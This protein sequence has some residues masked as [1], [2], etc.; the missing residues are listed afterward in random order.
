MGTGLYLVCLIDFSLLVFDKGI[1]SAS[2]TVN[3]FGTFHTLMQRIEEK[4]T[5]TSDRPDFR[6]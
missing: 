6:I 2:G 1:S 4:Q 5:K 3:Q